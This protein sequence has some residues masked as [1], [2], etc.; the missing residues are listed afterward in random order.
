[1]TIIKRRAVLTGAVAAGGT[2][3]LSACAAETVPV[4]TTP[5]SATVED[6]PAEPTGEQLLGPS[7]EIMVGSGKKYEISASLTILV[8]RPQEDTFRA[9][10]ASCTHSGCIVSGV[11]D[12]QIACGCHGARFD[13]ESGEVQAGPAKS[14]LGKI[15][16]EVRGSDLFAII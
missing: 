4:A 13:P 5:P 6:A 1:M 12:D 8:T 14:P 10:N 16:V 15:M 2:L 11:R 7:S 3:A 9:F